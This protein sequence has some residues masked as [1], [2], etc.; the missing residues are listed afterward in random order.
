MTLPFI[1]QS[2]VSIIGEPKVE[3]VRYKEGVFLASPIGVA[4]SVGTANSISRGLPMTTTQVLRRG[5]A[6]L[7]FPYASCSVGRGASVR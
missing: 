6:V 3:R 2:G 7:S 4:S 5:A 1:V